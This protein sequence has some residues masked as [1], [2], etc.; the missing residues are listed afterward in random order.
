MSRYSITSRYS[1]QEV[2]L[3]HNQVCNAKGTGDYPR[4]LVGAKADLEQDREVSVIEGK[5]LA[6]S[7]QC[8]FFEVLN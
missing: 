1:F 2:L 6:E 8:S 4:V 5:K 7:L 3:F